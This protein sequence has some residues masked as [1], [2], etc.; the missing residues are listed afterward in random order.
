MDTRGHCKLS[1]F[2]ISKQLDGPQ[3]MS[4]TVT[5]SFRFMSPERYILPPAVCA[6]Y[7]LL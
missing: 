3:S 6:L 1:D 5:G 4:E 2:G 7:V